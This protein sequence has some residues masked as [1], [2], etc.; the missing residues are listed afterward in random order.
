MALLAVTAKM[1]PGVL[2]DTSAAGS[3][4]VCGS[5]S[6]SQGHA[7]LCGD[8]GAPG[9]RSASSRLTFRGREP[10]GDLGPAGP[11]WLCVKEVSGGAGQGGCAHHW[12]LLAFCLWLHLTCCVCDN[13]WLPAGLGG[14]H[15]LAKP[16]S[17][18]LLSKVPPG[19]PDP[20]LSVLS[21][22]KEDL[23]S[24]LPIHSTSVLP[25]QM[26]GSNSSY[27]MFPP[28]LHPSNTAKWKWPPPTLC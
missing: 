9:Q 13:T 16:T 24:F 28:V 23:R 4:I 25:H 18:D 12:S 2:G 19:V 11:P 5:P 10:A 21:R 20:P 15:L 14:I 7:C 6:P 8:R 26:Q 22:K 27:R 3:V 17:S 1:L